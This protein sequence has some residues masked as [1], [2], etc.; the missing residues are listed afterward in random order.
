MTMQVYPTP[1]PDVNRVLGDFLART[2]DILGD[3][4]IGMYLYGSL[5]L[6]DFDPHGSDIDYIVVTESELPGGLVAA[7]CGMH[8]DFSASDSPWATKIE[9]AYVPR[10]ALRDGAPVDARYPQIEKGT[11]LVLER[12]ES[13]WSF[14]CHT[15]REYGITVAG[16]QPRTLIGPVDPHSMR[17][18]AAA[19][20]NLWLEQ[21]RHDHEWLAW[22]RHR[23]NQ[24]FVVLTLCRMLYTLDSGTVASK[25]A[26]ARWAQERLG[27]RWAGLIAHALIGQHDSG[28]TPYPDVGDTIALLQY[29]V[30]RYREWAAP[31]SP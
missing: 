13:G 18:A 16:P 9:A 23:G 1:Y 30:E 24:A 22:L 20:V 28:D 25:P 8:A 5:A 19:Q 3:R 15:L 12:L 26:A 11:T 17:R 4:F 27:A 10:G 21:A 7:L 6:G 31:S 2:H 14:Q 29:T